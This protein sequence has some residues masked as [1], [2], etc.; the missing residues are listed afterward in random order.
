MVSP[1]VARWL[2]VLHA[3]LAVAVVAAA[4]HWLTW[5]LKLVRG[6]PGRIRSVRR[7]ALIAMVLYLATMAAGLVLYPTYKARVK[8][9]Y[10]TRS[11]AVSADARARLEASED[12]VARLEGR[13]AREANP[14]LLDALERDAS[15]RSARVARWFDVKEH[16]VAVGVVLG[17][18][19]LAVL[20]SWDPRRDGRGPSTFAIGAVAGVVAITWLAAVIGLVTSAT[21]SF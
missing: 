18:A 1:A 13:P 19:A 5:L 21:R 4:T 17:L 15:K 9:E 8:L 6:Q 11:T 3:A 12:Q 2:L 14:A 16:W 20:A 7:F 10:L